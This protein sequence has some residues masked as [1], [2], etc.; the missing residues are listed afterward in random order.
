ML[1]HYIRFLFRKQPVFAALNFAGL[2]IGMTAA[3]LLFGYVRYEQR[4]DRQTPHAGQIWRVFNQT[5]GGTVITKDANTHSAVG[6]TLKAEVPGVIDF[7]RLYCGNSPE[8]VVLADQQPFEVSRCYTTDP[9]FLRLFPQKILQGNLTTCLHEPNLAVI[10]Q[11]QS[12]RIFGVGSTLGK[13]FR[14]TE[15]MMAGAYTVSAVVADPPENTHLK[16]D[17]LVSYATRYAKGHRD[18]FESYWDYNYFQLEPNTNPDNVRHKLSEINETFLK[19]EGIRLDIQRFTDIHLYSDLTYELEPNGSASTVRFLGLIALLILGIA[20]INYIN[21]ATAFARERSKEVGVR[22]A[23]GASKGMLMGQFVWE[24]FLL[25]TAAFVVSVF[26]FWQLSPWFGQLIGRQMTPGFDPLFW[27]GSAGC[28]LLLALLSALYPALQ[29][30]GF[31]PSE[32][33]AGNVKTGKGDLLHKTL[34]MTQFACSIGLI[35]GV[36]VVGNQLD[37][38]KNH[39]LGVQLDQLVAVKSARTQ[40]SEDTLSVANLALFKTACTQMPGVHGLASSN[41]VPGLGINTISGSNRPMH[42][43]QKPEYVRISSYFVNTDERFFDLFGIQVLAGQHHFFAD[44][45]A[46][47]RTV[48]INQTML[49]ALGFPRPEA[50]IGQQIAYENSEGGS[51]MTIG[52]VVEDFHIESLKTTPKPTLYYC[53]APD[54]LNYLTL[55]I[56][57]ENMTATLAAL[58]SS[59]AGIYPDK[60]FRYWFLDEHFAHQYRSETQFGQLFGLFSGLAVVI[61]CLG[62][63]GLTAFNMQRRRKEIG[64]RKVL[65]ASVVGITGLL[66]K[67]FIK[68]LCIAFV[69]AAP[70]AFYFMDLWLADFAYRIDIEWWMFVLAGGM[71]VLAALS[72][73]AIQSVRAALAN[74]VESLRSE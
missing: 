44:P 58:Q 13:T 51:T 42:W 16:F 37:F 59:W 63:L 73:V 5:S 62:L 1:T 64:I 24:N 20:F 25:S 67:D 48:S 70:I 50:A 9:G 56:A 57:P 33:L 14:I 18:N 26:C 47:Y 60:P 46:R 32:A 6:P 23:L 28:V 15:G 22:K 30:S 3:L 40:G 10:T 19:T 31:R 35:F 2:I 34:V 71:A 52:A 36:L 66:T 68:L 74:P 17:V 27:A 55:K 4:Y 39:G 49:K 53:F 61:S 72:M 7:A 29:L 38:L 45:A 11:S 65:G 8:V 54:Q 43:T 41:I 69:I 21:L 12:E